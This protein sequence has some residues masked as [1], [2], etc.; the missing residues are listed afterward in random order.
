MTESVCNGALSQCQNTHTHF[1]TL[2]FLSYIVS[3]I[4]ACC[5]MAVGYFFFIKQ[6][7]LITMTR[8]QNHYQPFH[9][10][11]LLTEALR[12]TWVEFTAV[13]LLMVLRHVKRFGSCSTIMDTHCTCDFVLL[14]RQNQHI[15][16]T[17]FADTLAVKRLKHLNWW[18][19]WS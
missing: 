6:L 5:L 7:K 4:P 2:L 9:R 8:I 16:L 13:S 10:K 11:T 15:A 12:Y 14:T 18:F 3:D 17:T 1:D 19:L